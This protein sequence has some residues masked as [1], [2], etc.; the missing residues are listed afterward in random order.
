MC[1]WGRH[2]LAV[3]AV[4]SI[5]MLGGCGREPTVPVSPRRF[6]QQV[7]AGFVYAETGEPVAGAKVRVT[8]VLLGTLMPPTIFV[9]GCS[10]GVWLVDSTV[11]TSSTGTFAKTI[12]FAPGGITMCVA[13]EVTPPPG[14]S[15]RSGL[16][17]VPEMRATSDTDVP[18]TTRVVLLLTRN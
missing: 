16:A 1:A 9:G 6:G 5:S 11:T 7:L 3:A 17:W 18:D 4:L 15:L 12:G 2:R 10:G 13:A 14:S 8:S